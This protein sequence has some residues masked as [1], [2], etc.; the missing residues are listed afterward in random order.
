MLWHKKRGIGVKGTAWWTGE[1][2]QAVREKKEAYLDCLSSRGNR[3]LERVKWDIYRD[4][5][6]EVKRLVRES[7]KQVEEEFGRQLSEKWGENKKL[8][9]KEVKRVRGGMVGECRGIKDERGM[10]MNDKEQVCQRWKEYYDQLLNVRNERESIVS[11]MGMN[12]VHGTGRPVEEREIIREEVCRA[13]KKLKTGKAPGIDGIRGEML[14]CGGEVVVDWIFCLCKLAWESSVVP[15]DWKKGIIIPIYKGKGDRWECNS[16]RGISLLSIVGKVYGRIVIDRV[17]GITEQLISEE[18]GG[19]REG[20]GCV[21]QIFTV[22]ILAEKYL[23]RGKRLYL[24]FVDLEKAYD[25]VD[26]NALWQVLRVYGVGGR[27][28]KAVQS[29]YEGATAV[30]R[31]NGVMSGSFELKMGLK[32]GCVMSPWLFNIFMDGVLREMKART[33]GRGVALNLEGRQWKLSS[34]LFA[35]DAVLVAESEEDLGRLVREFDNVCKRR[36]LTLNVGKTKVMVMERGTDTQCRICLNEQ[37]LENVSEFKYL[38]SVLNKDGSLGS[39][40]EERVKQGRKVSGALKSVTRNRN[41]NVKVKKTLHDSVLM[42]TMLYGCETWTLLEGQKSRLR[43][44]EMGYLRSACGVTWRDRWTNER[45]RRQCGIEVDAIGQVK[46]KV[47]QWFGHMERMGSER[48][49]KKVYS[50]EVQG[51]R[52]RG[53]PRAR[54][55]DKV[56]EYM[57]EGGL[58]WEEGLEMTGDRVGWRSFCRGHP[59]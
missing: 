54:W 8:F 58:D 46:R 42:P 18:Q 25:R 24:A 17:R 10:M 50:S 49:T 37:V 7:K 53:R 27:L 48:L 55:K 36:N 16:H 34:V 39:E 12:S 43:A 35:D 30:V 31:A 57:E 20:R 56:K 33:L 40:V 52:R 21:D 9:W 41:V 29:L 23:E 3:E 38:G 11:C 2:E 19:F 44:V 1:V 4:K 15:E 28:L 51:V 32:Q 47:L 45:V 26:R 59:G 14:K 22:R 13:L 6:R 5:N